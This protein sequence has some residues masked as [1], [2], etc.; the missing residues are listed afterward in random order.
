MAFCSDGTFYGER[1]FTCPAKKGFFPL[2]ENCRPDSRFVPDAQANDASYRC[3]EG[4]LLR[5]KV[6]VMHS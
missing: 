3:A 1:Y 4:K 2:L 6:V 5:Q